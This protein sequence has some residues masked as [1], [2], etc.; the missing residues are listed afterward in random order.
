[1][2]ILCDTSSILMLLR[3]V[4]QMFEDHKYN[5][6]TIKE[7]YEEITRTTKFKT[8]YPWA[9]TLRNRVKA[10]PAGQTNTPDVNFYNEAISSLNESG[11]VDKK[12][13]RLFDLSR[14][15]MK[16]MSCALALRYFVSSGDGGMIR[17]IE[18]QFPDE[19]KGN[20][21]PL[22]LIN[23]WLED[24]LISWDDEKQKLMAEWNDNEEHAQ[25][26]NEIAKFR[27]LTKRQYPG[28]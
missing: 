28:S 1:M 17:F 26:K 3:I 23:K 18:Q 7:V 20:I 25:P 19:F 21:S 24:K 16:I 8:R 11:V 13:A 5:C 22:G 14:V 10:L 4:P 6:V 12:T 15:D 27:R 9:G 2:I